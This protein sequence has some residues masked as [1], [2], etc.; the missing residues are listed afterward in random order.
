MERFRFSHLDHAQEGAKSQPEQDSVAQLL[1]YPHVS[2]LI[3]ST[4]TAQPLV[5]ELRSVVSFIT[6][7]QDAKQQL[8]VLNELFAQNSMNDVYRYLFTHQSMSQDEVA[9]MIM[10]H[11]R[12]PQV[13]ETF[14]P[15]QETYRFPLA[16]MLSHYTTATLPDHWKDL[17]QPRLLSESMK[18]SLIERIPGW[19]LCE[20]S[21]S[22]LIRAMD[23]GAVTGVNEVMLVKHV[24][25][26]AGLCVMN[27]ASPEGSFVR[28]N[29]YAPVGENVRQQLRDAHDNGIAHLS[30]SGGTW[31]L[32]RSSIDYTGIDASDIINQAEDCL[33]SL[34]EHLPQS[35]NGG[36]RAIYRVGY[37]EAY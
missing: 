8:S 1:V 27:A 13:I 3:S 20:S 34:P 9:R 14:L 22:C 17:L 35:I 16:A 6:K 18:P 29:W 10:E 5:P 25:R 31:T 30:F 26:L 23:D 21:E 7:D 4:D 24:G 36:T 32:M 33:D 11:R 37:E 2:R 19:F 28:G 12:F 15:Q